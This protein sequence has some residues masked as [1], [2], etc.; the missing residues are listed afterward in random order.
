[1]TKS[2]YKVFNKLGKK[3]VNRSD[4]TVVDSG[5]GFV[6]FHTNF[7]SLYLTYDNTGTLMHC[8]TDVERSQAHEALA[9]PQ[10]QVE[11]QLVDPYVTVIDDDVPF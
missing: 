3:Q 11:M 6:T 10:A 5:S 8:Q 2:Q 4:V 9:K 7:P 1:M